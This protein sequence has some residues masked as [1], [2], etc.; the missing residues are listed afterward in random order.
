MKIERPKGTRDFTP[1]EM[2]ERNYVEK[3]IES[4]FERANYSQI[5]TPTFEHVELFEEKSGEDIKAHLYTF[6][7]K[8]K[9]VLCLRPEATAPVCRMYAETL[10]NMPMPVKAYYFDPMFRYEE[11]QKGRYREF[12]QLGL[13]LIGAK[14]ALA[15][16]EVIYLAYSCLKKLGLRF[17]LELSH[18]GVMRGLLSSLKLSES[19][20]RKVIACVDKKDFVEVKKIVGDETF[21]KLVSLRGGKKELE[22]ARKLL[23]G[24]GKASEALNELAEITEI[25]DLLGVEYVVD[26]GVA[27][28]LEYYTGMV[29]E[30]RV[31]CLGAQNQIAGGG[32]YDDLIELFAGVSVP[33]VGFAFGFDRVVEA[34]KEQKISFPKK[35]VDVVVAPTSSDVRGE[36]MKIAADLRSS[37]IVDVDLME[38]RLGRILEYASVIN[39]KYVVI[40][41]RKDLGRGEVTV[42]NML[43]GEQ[44][45]IPLSKIKEEIS[46]DFD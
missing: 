13:E 14:G 1:A 27:R 22:E 8:K 19:D 32:R 10:R 15:D 41:G 21:F 18:L 29:F 12:W 26:F 31:D 6:E 7:D 44:R 37:F 5:K 43:S 34:M 30:V 40:V 35:E 3:V 28:G 20:Q 42:R 24:Y 38:R 36:A 33:A 17:R 46:K 25:L 11:P 45:N 16:A 23:H 4:V 2:A 39:A 9:R